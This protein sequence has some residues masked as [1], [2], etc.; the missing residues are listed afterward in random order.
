MEEFLG[1]FSMKIC[2][3]YLDDL[4]IFSKT[5]EENLD[6]LDKVLQRLQECN[7]KLSADKCYF[8]QRRVKFLGHIVSEG[9]ETD[10]E[11]NWKSKKLARTV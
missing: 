8:L 11:K 2:V 1:D 10:P 9:I 6:R 7:L 3:I 5:L 4:I